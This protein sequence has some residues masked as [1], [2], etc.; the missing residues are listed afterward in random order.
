MNE[1]SNPN[2]WLLVLECQRKG[3][4]AH[5]LSISQGAPTTLHPLELRF[6]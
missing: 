3:A 6:Q 4:G 5:L 1:V 2:P